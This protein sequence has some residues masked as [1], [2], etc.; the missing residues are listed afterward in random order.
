MNIYKTVLFSLFS[1]FLNYGCSN[2]N[3]NTSDSINVNQ[4]SGAGGSFEDLSSSQWQSNCIQGYNVQ[5]KYLLTFANGQLIE[6]GTLYND[7]SNC[8]SIAAFEQIRRTY[9]FITLGSSTD[10]LSTKVN[11]TLTKLELKILTNSFAQNQNSGNVCG[12]T[13]WVNNGQY[14]DV[15]NTNCFAGLKTTFSI[16]KIINNMVYFGTSSNE[17]DGSSDNKRHIQLTTNSISKI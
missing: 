4:T 15:T 13:D 10:G 7:N 3:S 12:K 2:S 16:F 14:I 5:S 9:T 17:F 6:I 8:N 11:L 1:A